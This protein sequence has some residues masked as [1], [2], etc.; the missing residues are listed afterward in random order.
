MACQAWGKWA[1][2]SSSGASASLTGSASGGLT[3]AFDALG[4]AY[5]RLA[6]EQSVKHAQDEAGAAEDAS[7]NAAE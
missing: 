3:I 4:A 6:A 2:S 5:M 7:R 1:W